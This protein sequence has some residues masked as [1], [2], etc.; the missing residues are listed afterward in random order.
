MPSRRQRIVR[1]ITAALI[2]S[3]PALAAHPTPIVGTPANHMA[4]EVLSSLVSTPMGQAAPPI[5]WSV[6]LVESARINAYIDPAGHIVVTSG[7]ASVF[8]NERGLW[9]AV[10]GHEIGHFVIHR[11]LQA[12]LPRFQAELDKAHGKAQGAQGQDGSASTVRLVPIGGGLG[13]Q[14]RARDREFEADRVGLMLMAQA[15][16][17]P[18]YVILL[19]RMLH[20]F[21]G[22]E[23]K[24]TEV[25]SS[26]PRWAGREQRTREDREA[27]EA[28]FRSLWPDAAKS[29]GGPPPPFGSI[30]AIEVE[31]DGKG[32]LTLQVPVRI[33][34]VAGRQVRVEAVF[35]DKDRRVTTPLPQYRST[36]G[37]ESLVLN[38]NLATPPVGEQ[39][40]PL[41]M[42]AGALPGGEKKLKAM[43]FL[44]AGDRLVDLA[45]KPIEVRF[46]P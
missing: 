10:L 18:D 22:N 6:I 32:S 27:A 46:A 15:G 4:E 7:M 26:H 29:P 3:W 24:L 39:K 17:H 2:V 25:F 36:D 38:T 34:N 33:T 19:E 1:T 45:T 43:V 14:K 16:Y 9:A 37:L 11:Q 44:L 23:P 35:L 28:I 5:P 30:G 12:Y 42:P 8:G 40:V 20:A 21:F 31:Q 41:S 13:R